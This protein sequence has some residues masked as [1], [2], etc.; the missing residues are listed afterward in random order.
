MT[1]DGT[2][3]AF[4]HETTIAKYRDGED[5]PYETVQVDP[6]WT[7]LDGTEITDQD[8]IRRLEKAAE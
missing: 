2:R 5:E 1:E 7:D 3:L 6:I 4:K 8:R